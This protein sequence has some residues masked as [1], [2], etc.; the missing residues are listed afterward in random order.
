MT[1][2]EL[3]LVAIAVGAAVA[4]ADEP[5]TGSP[6]CLRPPAGRPDP[7]GYTIEAIQAQSADGADQAS[8]RDFGQAR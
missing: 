5:A 4:A 3:L 8:A 1:G 7:D 2:I 6:G